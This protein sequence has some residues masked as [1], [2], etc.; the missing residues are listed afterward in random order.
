M[1]MQ[2]QSDNVSMKLKEDLLVENRIG[3]L[4]EKNCLL[5]RNRVCASCGTADMIPAGSCYVCRNC[6]ASN[7]CSWQTTAVAIRVETPLLQIC[8]DSIWKSRS[9]GSSML[10][11]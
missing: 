1:M 4:P 9:K 10:V 8:G 2:N 7:G 6:G 5:K 11:V 3:I